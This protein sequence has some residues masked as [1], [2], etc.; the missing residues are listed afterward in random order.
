[1]FLEPPPADDHIEDGLEFDIC[2]LFDNEG[3][4]L[5]HRLACY[6]L[7]GCVLRGGSRQAV[8]V[9]FHEGARPMRRVPLQH[10]REEHF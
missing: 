8:Y 1:M 7:L 9:E 10:S 2:E 3:N 5:Q 4:S 6:T